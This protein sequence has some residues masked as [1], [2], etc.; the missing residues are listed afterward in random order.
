[1]DYIRANQ[2]TFPDK[3]PIL[4]IVELLDEFTGLLSIPNLIIGLDITKSGWT[5]EMSIKQP[6]VHTRGIVSSRLRHSG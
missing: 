3:L 6:F 4:I 5:N 1:M 2:L